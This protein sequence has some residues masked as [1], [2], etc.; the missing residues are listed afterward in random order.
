LYVIPIAPGFAAARKNDDAIA[1]P[2]H[3]APAARAILL[4]PP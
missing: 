3:A 4:P 2:T 1:D